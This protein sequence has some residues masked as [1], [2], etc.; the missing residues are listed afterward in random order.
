VNY[1]TL[2]DHVVESA[3][4]RRRRR[5]QPAGGPGDKI[6]PPTYPGEGRNKIPRHVYEIRQLA[7][8][9]H[10]AV[11]LIDSVQSQANRME[12]ALVEAIAG[13]LSIP[14]VEV[15]FAETGIDGLAPISSLVA[16]HRLFDAVLRDSALDGVPFMKST[17]GIRLQ[18]ATLADATAILEA[19]PTALV[20]GIWNS[21]GEG[22]GLG[23]KFPRVLTSEI[24]G[25]DVPVREIKGS[26]GTETL[27]TLGQR[28]GSRIDPL[29]ILRKVEV[30]KTKAGWDTDPARLGDSKNDRPK[31]A[32]PS[33]INHGNIAPSVQPLGVTMAYAEHVTVLSLAGLRRLRFGNAKVSGSAR[34]YLAILALLAI[35]E[36]DRTGYALRSRCDLVPDGPA[37]FEFVRADGSV[38]PFDFDLKASHKLYTEALTNLRAAGIA[39]ESEPVK[40]TP[41]PKLVEIIR[42]SRELALEGEGG[43]DEAPDAAS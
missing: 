12:E 19:S 41:Q 37:P 29:G 15:D 2:V 16:P 24:V 4:V 9:R 40:L 14:V 13:G 25:I 6:F 17:L 20:F 33:E 30:Y 22:G 3:A 11:V 1:Q 43:E 26:D 36:Q 28:T 42:R 18:T 21:T 7:D 34:T 5:L 8:G 31:K 39:L 27:Q 23:A 10:V 35:V 32:R 38:E